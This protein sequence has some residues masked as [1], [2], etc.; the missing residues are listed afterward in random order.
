MRRIS[1]WAIVLVLGFAPLVR[2]DAPTKKPAGLTPEQLVEQLTSKDYRQRD[3]ASKALTALGKEALPALQKAKAHPDPEVRRRLDELIPPL[4]R[5]VLL[6][7]RQLSLH[8]TNKPIREVL[9]ELSKVTGY[10]FQYGWE[11]PVANAPRDKVVYSFH[12]DKLPFWQAI[13]KITDATGMMLQPYYGGWGMDDTTLMFYGA[14]SYVPY[15]CYSGPFKLIAFGFNYSRSNNFGQLPKNPMQ[16]NQPPQESLA[17]QLQIA[18]EPRLPLISVGQPKLTA[19]LDDENH[20]MLPPAA[21]EA[22]PNNPYGNRF[23][24]GWWG[25]GWMQ[26][27]Q[28]NLQWPS[29]TAK[30]VKLLKGTMPITLLADQKPT[31]VTEKILACKGKNLKAAGATFH[32][33]D[34]TGAPG[35]QYTIKI[36][37]TED[38]KENPNDYSRIQTLQ[39]RL[40]LRDDKGNKLPCLVQ[41][42]NWGGP[43]NAQFT[44]TVQPTNNAKLGPPAKLTYYAWVLMQ[45]EVAFEFK[46]LPLP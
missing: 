26:Q 5:A 14:D 8:V 18:T 28:A 37:V 19:A 7:P 39:Q 46:D 17:V 31:I 27:T 43:N 1:C 45:H 9:A 10:K 24:G 32:I 42:T 6:T 21:P 20:S 11:T 2:G 30:K 33:E 3:K 44:L 4:E 22:D 23:W 29:K 15:S 40:E 41:I 13:D 25:R 36:S 38:N 34:I 16:P 35:K 12:F